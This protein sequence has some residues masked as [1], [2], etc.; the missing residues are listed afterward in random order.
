MTRVASIGRSLARG[1]AG[2]ARR[3]GPLEAAER[4]AGF[5]F[6]LPVI[7][8]TGSL[9]F[10]PILQTV[11]YSFTQWD[12]I[13]ATWVG[14]DNFRRLSSDPVFWRVL[15]N[16]VLLL[17]AIP[18]AI[19]IPLLVAFLLH[20]HV[21]GWRFFRS[22][23]F[24]PTSI[25]WVVIGMVAIRVF[26]RRGI[27]NDLL[28]MLGI[29]LTTDLLTTELGA[30]LAVSLTFIWSV[31]GTN[32][33]IFIT[34]MATLDRDVYE[35]ARVDGAG[36]WAVFRYVTIPLLM[37]FIQ[38]A[39]VLTVITGFTALFSLIFIMTTGGPGYGTTTLEFFV[40]QKAFAQGVFGYAAAIGTFL[41]AIVF[42]IGLVQ[43]R[44]LRS[45]ED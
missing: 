3:A 26:A 37:R 27:L 31:F 10:L 43:R 8:L 36:P 35:A 38:F 9:L 4:R 29:P 21:A 30:M 32:T 13:T 14:L 33:I 11:Y 44:L 45:Q 7:L 34:G 22:V 24:L 20:Q 42:L 2:E 18:F 6:A 16:N 19:L 23:Y 28:R 41:F 12:G 40:Y 39:F 15:A 17:A 5:L 1:G 25:S